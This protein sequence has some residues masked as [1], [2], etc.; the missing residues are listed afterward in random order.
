V[1]DTVAKVTEWRLIGQEALGIRE[2]PD[3]NSPMSPERAKALKLLDAAKKRLSERTFDVEKALEGELPAT[4]DEILAARA[5]REKLLNQTPTEPIP[6]DPQ[7]KVKLLVFLDEIAYPGKKLNESLEPLKKL[8]TTNPNLQIFG[9]TSKTYSK[10]GLKRVSATTSF[11][12]P[13]LNGEALSRDLLI[14]R[15]PTFIFVA[16]TTKQQYRLEGLRD[17]EEIEKVIRV[18]MG[19]K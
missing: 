8:L 5:E 6:V 10:I 1:Q 7:G 19:G 11:P 14:T 18:M 12:F 15:Y 16:P 4:E 17:T 13:L 2:T 9:L 3:P